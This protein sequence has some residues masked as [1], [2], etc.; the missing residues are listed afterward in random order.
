VSLTKDDA[1]S[2]AYAAAFVVAEPAPGEEQERV[3]LHSFRGTVGADWDLDSVVAA[4]EDAQ[5]VEWAAPGTLARALGH[6]LL[7]R[8]RDG[9][10]VAFG[11]W[12]P[13]G[14]T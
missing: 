5:S 10:L 13:E 6:H 7:V 8:E 4:I 14:P 9:R 2:A 12:Q 1:I 11:V 3:V